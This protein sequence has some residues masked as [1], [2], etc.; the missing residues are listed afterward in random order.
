MK[1]LQLQWLFALAASI[2]AVAQ[3]GPPRRDRRPPPPVPPILALFDTNR[4]RVL[5]ADEI[6]AAAEA[7]GKL[8]RDGDGQID[9][10][11]L[12]RPPQEPAD[13]VHRPEG[14]RPR[15][16]LITALDTDQDGTISAT[17]LAAAP[18]SL[19][20]LDR[21]GDGELSPEELRS[22]GPPPPENGEVE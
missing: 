22:H 5:S 9:L 1:P 14:K 15:P 7:L 6:Q 19:K 11:E 4:N 10:E 21:N 8:D 17:E 12:R 3:P 2:A 20:G 16:P 18:E 13:P